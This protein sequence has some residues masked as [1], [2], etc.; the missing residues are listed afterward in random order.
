M[1][2]IRRIAMIVTIALVA[3]ACGAGTTT[4]EAEP[5][6][7]EFVV[8]GEESL[9][10]SVVTAPTT[11]ASEGTAGAAESEVEDPSAFVSTTDT[12]PQNE[13]E[14]S[15]ITGLFEALAVFASCLEDEGYDFIGR[16]DPT[17]EADDAVNDAGYIDALTKCAAVSQI[18]EAFEAQ[19]SESD[20][21]DT[22]GIETRNR[23]LVY[24]TD[25]MVG[26]GWTIGTIATDERGLNSPTELA[27]PDGQ[28]L[29]D[30]PDLGECATIAGA[31]YDDELA[32]AGAAQEGDTEGN[33]E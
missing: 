6:T 21:L 14:G 31:A 7:R 22:E 25:C 33:D 24:W 3:A 30:S 23:Q 17:L 2:A 1:F 12:V 20:S 26:R 19:Q 4:D 29:I 16:P 32:Q 28:S 15:A 9:P 5:A 8:Q 18:I 13:D 10:D 27:A 11:S